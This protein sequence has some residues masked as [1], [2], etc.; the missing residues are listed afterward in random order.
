MVSVAIITF[1]EVTFGGS[2]EEVNGSDEVV[3][4]SDEE[5]SD[6]CGNNKEVRCCSGEVNDS[7]EE[8]CGSVEEVNG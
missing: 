5:V 7:D 2:D 3:S 1:V 6:V 4:G 8:T